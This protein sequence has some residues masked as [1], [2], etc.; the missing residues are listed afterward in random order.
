MEGGKKNGEM[1]G[2]RRRK[3]VEESDG[4]NDSLMKAEA[5]DAAEGLASCF[6]TPGFFHATSPTLLC[7]VYY[8]YT[9]THICIHVGWLCD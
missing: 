4:A 3:F 6:G 8:T 7:V 1:G 9:R 5:R 2:E